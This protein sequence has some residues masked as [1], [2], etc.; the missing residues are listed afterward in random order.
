MSGLYVLIAGLNGAAMVALAA[1]GAH[2]QNLASPDTF[3]AAWQLHA[4]HSAAILTL[5]LIQKKGAILQAGFFLMA[6]GICLFCGALYLSG[7]TGQSGGLAAPAGGMALVASWLA[8]AAAGA[9]RLV[10]HGKA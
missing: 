2:G 10:N 7:A 6:A 8:I 9:L 3:Q 1:Y 4:V 5:A